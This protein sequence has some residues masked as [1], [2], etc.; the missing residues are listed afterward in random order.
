[1][2]NR[3]LLLALVTAVPSAL[4]AGPAAAADPDPS[5]AVTMIVPYAASGATDTVG[6]IL[7]ESMGPTLG[8]QVI[9]ENV[10]GASGTIGRHVAE[11]AEAILAEVGG[12][13]RP[14]AATAAAMQAG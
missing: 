2:L 13:A 8:Q 10:G 9:V 3:R 5:R 12:A 11:Q 1:M 6:R 7:A 14:T 4:A